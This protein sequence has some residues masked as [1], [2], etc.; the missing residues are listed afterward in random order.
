LD[1]NHLPIGQR[2]GYWN[3]LCDWFLCFGHDDW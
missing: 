2:N 1:A 3:E